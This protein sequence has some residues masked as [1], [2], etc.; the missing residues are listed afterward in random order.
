MYETIDKRHD[1]VTWATSGVTEAAAANF[2]YV[3]KAVNG[4]QAWDLLS[5]VSIL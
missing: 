3:D 5:L 1:Y 2:I 4:L